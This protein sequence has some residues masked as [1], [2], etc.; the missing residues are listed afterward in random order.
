M[1]CRV[2]LVR[3]DVSE[4]PSAS[5]IRVTRIGEIGTTLAATSV[6]RLLVAACVVPSTPILVTLMTEPLGST[7][8][9][10]LRRAIRRNIPED[11]ILHSHR[12]ENLKSYIWANCLHNVG[13]SICH[14]PVAPTIC[15][16]VG[17]NWYTYA[18]NEIITKC[19]LFSAASISV[20]QLWQM[21]VPAYRK[22]WKF[23][24]HRFKL[25][26]WGEYD[27]VQSSRW[28][29]TYSWGT[30]CHMLF[31]PLHWFPCTKLQGMTK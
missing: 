10:V 18:I 6:R 23:C 2:D 14:N 31:L 1:L 26:F 15:Y 30:C 12:R 9:S 29:G 17:F 4:E 20:A 13:S 5:F 25:C 21:D 11:S 8:T 27:T 28:R 7:E 22:P 19:R 24:S 3:T 16:R